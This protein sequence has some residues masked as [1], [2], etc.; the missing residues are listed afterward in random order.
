MDLAG[1]VAVVTGGASGIGAAVVA[2]LAK[3]G[4]K[5]VVWDIC[6]DAD[7][8][9]DVSDQAQVAEAMRWTLANHAVP[10]ILVAAAGVPA[11]SCPA[12]DMPS[13]DLART[14]AVNTYG[15]LFCLQAVTQELIR[16][17]LAGSVVA[18]SSANGIVADEGLA[19]YSMSKAAVNMLVKIMAREVGRFDIRVNAVAPGPTATPMLAGLTA[20][21]D[22]VAEVA[23]RTPLGRLGTPE[24][25]GAAIVNLLRSEWVTGQVL[26]V[27]G[28]STLCTGRTAWQ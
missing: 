9:C 21:P 7:V 15:V 19:A 2:E 5:P 25:V 10:T 27:D 11:S 18:V 17:G 13:A 26:A 24:L 28:G 4:A 20:D 22:Y 3:E 6:A 12:A 16:Q 23:R 1:R 8:R 14:F